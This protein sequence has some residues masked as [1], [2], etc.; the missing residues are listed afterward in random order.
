MV[1]FSF[2]LWTPEIYLRIGSFHFYA[3]LWK[4]LLLLTA[5]LASRRLARTDRVAEPDLHSRL[6][7]ACLLASAAYL[8]SVLWPFGLTGL[9]WPWDDPPPHI[10]YGGIDY[11]SGQGTPDP[12]VDTY[13]CNSEEE[14]RDGTFLDPG[15]IESLEQV[16]HIGGIFGGPALYFA[17]ESSGGWLVVRPTSDC[18]IPYPEWI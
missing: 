1:R 7:A 6:R 16:G 3:S 12:R 10:R 11:G 14:I 13:G 9:A 2:S 18:W 4:V 15:S 5:V 17:H 8:M